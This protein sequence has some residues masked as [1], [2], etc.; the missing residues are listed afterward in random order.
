MLNRSGRTVLFTG[1]LNGW[2]IIEWGSN[3]KHMLASVRKARNI[4]AD[5]LCFG[6]FLVSED[7]PGFWD[8]LENSVGDGIFQLVD[9]YDYSSHITRTGEKV[10]ESTRN[11]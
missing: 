1:D 6:H 10:L 4:R 3:Q 7:L 8:K 5:Y 2:Y 9:R 11:Q